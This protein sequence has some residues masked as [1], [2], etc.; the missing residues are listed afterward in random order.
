MI[1]TLFSDIFELSERGALALLAASV[2]AALILYSLMFVTTANLLAWYTRPLY[3][4]LRILKDDPLAQWRLLLGFS[5]Q[6]GV[7]LIG[8][9]AASRIESPEMRRKAWVIILGGTILIAAVLLYLYPF[10]AADI[11]DNILHG[12][13]RGVYNAN[14]F[15]ELAAEYN[16]DP[17][18][19]Y[20]AWRYAPSAY[21]PAWELL[22]GLAARVAGS[23]IV[24]NI[25]VFKLLPGIFLVGTVAVV[26][27]LLNRAAPERALSGAW[28]VAMNPIVL[29]ETLGNGHNDMA[30]AFWMVLAAWFISR[31]RYTRAVTALVAG[32]LF[33]YIPALL[34]PAA[35]WI[36]LRSLRNTGERVRF[37]I[38]TGIACTAL[39]V[40]IF[41]PFWEGVDTL[42]ISR[43]AEMFTTSLPSIVF[44][45][46]TPM[47][48]K[49]AAG[50]WVSRAA[51]ALTG[52]FALW[53][54]WKAG[55][56]PTWV[57][58]T[59][60]GLTILLFYLLVTCLWFQPWYPVWLVGLAALLPA[61]LE[62]GLGIWV[63][64]ASLT[65][66]LV[67]APLVFR[68]E[69]PDPIEWLELRL[70]AGVMVLSWLAAWWVL[71]L[72]LVRNRSRESD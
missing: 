52:L 54:A 57:G 17:F 70:S 65:K 5:I 30:M 1:R 20:V 39:A 47:L 6:A 63:G 31:G 15:H 24:Q 42:G 58:F 40:I 60:A 16:Q 23:G 10:D 61:G 37:L 34:V 14:P 41:Y 66:P 50:A 43:R 4:L 27:S 18:Y 25:L 7:Y 46:L 11:F 72:K 53:Q 51:V 49:A 26:A 28:L 48:G 12:R 69:P 67:I 21:G 22:A 3:D 8:W 59:R 62:Q 29:Y 68:Q 35:V 19:N 38:G 55:K 45:F 2:A 44:H 64:F 32:A 71:W 9:R 33:K 56:E 13:I 36:G